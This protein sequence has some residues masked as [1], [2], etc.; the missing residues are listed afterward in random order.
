VLSNVQTSK[1]KALLHEGVREGG[2]IDA[3]FLYL[4]TACLNVKT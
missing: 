3:R 2:G 1:V 4:G